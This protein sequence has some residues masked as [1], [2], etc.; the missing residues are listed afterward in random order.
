V[1]P[2]GSSSE[3]EA[4]PC[5]DMRKDSLRKNEGVTG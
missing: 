5:E 4:I 2:P 1:R 3:E